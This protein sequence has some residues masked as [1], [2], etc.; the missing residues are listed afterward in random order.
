VA[1]FS[2]AVSRGA[3]NATFAFPAHPREGGIQLFAAALDSRLRGNER[4][5]HH[6]SFGSLI[7]LS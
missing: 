2:L 7:I 3:K 5:E 4:L 6:A 1:I